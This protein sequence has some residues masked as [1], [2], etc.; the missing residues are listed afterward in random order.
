[1]AMG[2]A[3]NK[4]KRATTMR[5]RRNGKKAQHELM[6]HLMLAVYVIYVGVTSVSFY[7][8]YGSE[9]TKIEQT[10]LGIMSKR[11]VY[12][13]STYDAE[14]GRTYIG[15]IDSKSATEEQLNK[16][17]NFGKTEVRIGVRI[18]TKDSTI[19]YNGKW[20]DRLN[21]R[22]GQD[23]EKEREYAYLI[24]QG[25]GEAARIEAVT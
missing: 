10:E 18:K 1:M 9:K 17:I 15:L 6:S 5:S 14:T 16:E 19:T 11:V 22:A 13:A 8:M 12:E 24:I 2:A 23:V 4:N 21:P 7:Y 20:F 3:H 25:K